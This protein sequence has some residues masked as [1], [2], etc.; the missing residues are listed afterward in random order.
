MASSSRSL[1]PIAA[2]IASIACWPVRADRA[3]A[4]S[5]RSV[6]SGASA[7]RWTLTGSRARDSA[8]YAHSLV[9]SSGVPMTTARSTVAP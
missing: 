3:G 4:I 9:K 2:R 1:R 8:V 6:R 5:A 7:T